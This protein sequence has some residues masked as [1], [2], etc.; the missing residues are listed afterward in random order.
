M[1]QI[2]NTATRRRESF[3]PREPGKVGIYA[4]GVTVYD[5]CH[6]GHARAVVV[7]DAIVRYLEYK[8]YEVNYVR[9]FTDVDDK[10]INRANAEGVSST[11][12]AER[13]IEA[14][15]EDMGKL[16]L[17]PADLEPKATEHIGEIIEA[18]EGLIAKEAAYEVD[19]DV[20][21]AVDKFPDY[22]QLS[23]RKLE[24]MKAGARIAVDERKRHPMDFALWKSAKPGEP[25][26]KSPWGQ[27][28]PGWHIECSAMSQKYLGQPFDIHGGGEDLVFP[29]HE[30]EKAQSEALNGR[31]FVKYW[32]HNGFVRIDQEK[33][34]KSLGNFLTIQEILS[35][36]HP[37]TLR[38]FLLSAHYRSPLDY[39]QEAMVE[40]D[41]GLERLYQ[42]LSRTEGVTAQGSED[43]GLVREAAQ[44]RE[45]FDAAMENDFNTA[46]ALGNLF[47]LA[48]SINRRLDA[49][50][51]DGVAQAREALVQLA[52]IL[53]LLGQRPDEYKAE[54]QAQ[55]AGSSGIDTELIEGLIA[56][57]SEARK[58]KD[59]ARADEV[60]DQLTEMGVVIFDSAE[61][62][63]WK[64]K[65]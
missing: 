28:R 12:I 1:I 49:D 43:G 14:F 25:A 60:R 62:T 22:G 61:G 7:F 42:V 64:L 39:S 51:L 26:W 48:R 6:I 32:V 27:G 40:A 20:Y 8:G 53:G 30:N 46:Q 33:M 38:L 3:E 50:D 31:Q 18:I 57:R 52:G 35:K 34:S 63:T 36:Y 29:H 41:E 54:R 45:A 16:G 19:G 24:D 4:C 9:N 5:R 37:Q 58:S 15:N 2:Y 11:E 13:Y 47:G 56:E 10:I 55:L 59:F 65:G 44:V 23:G 21:F 17:R